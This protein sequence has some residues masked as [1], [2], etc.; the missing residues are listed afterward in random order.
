MPVRYIPLI[1]AKAGEIVALDNLSANVAQRTF[2]LIHIGEN[3][4][5]SF[6]NQLSRAWQQPIAVDGS[7]N[8]R[9]ARSVAAY[10]NLVNSLRA[11]GTPA[12]PS[13]GYADPPAMLAAASALKNQDGIALKVAAAD[14]ASVAGWVVQIGWSPSEVDLVVDL[15]HVSSFDVATFGGYVAGL[16]QQVAPAMAQ[17]RSVTLASGAAPKDHGSL[18]YGINLVNRTDW[19]LWSIVHSRVPFEL[20][21]GDYCTGHPDL[22]EPPGPAMASATVSARYTL[23]TNWLIIKGRSTSGQ[24]GSPMANQYRSH[25][26]QIMG[27][28]GFG[29]LPNCW[30]DGRVQL[31]AAGTAGTSSR[32]KWS[33][34]AAN[35]HISLV[36]DRLP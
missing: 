15:K 31:A 28:A 12:I 20:D 26:Q 10:Q 25:A 30:A 23:D 32:Q 24:Y 19:D 22:T 7:F 35:R 3:I 13:I 18:N 2:P 21:Y 17:F 1:K 33:E 5:A 11:Q 16:F 34:I 29:G 27:Y 8:F 9:H 6:S 36:V 4:A 14:I